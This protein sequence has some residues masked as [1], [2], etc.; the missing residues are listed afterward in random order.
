MTK[1]KDIEFLLSYQWR[2][3]KNYQVISELC[4]CD[5]APLSD[6]ILSSTDEKAERVARL[7]DENG[8]NGSLFRGLAVDGDAISLRSLGRI[9]KQ[10]ETVPRIIAQINKSP[11]R[12][13]IP[14]GSELLTIPQVARLLGW[15]ESVVRERNKKGL[16]PLP[17]RIGGT[18]QWRK[19]E[20][21]R[22]LE[23]DCPARQRWEQIKQGRGI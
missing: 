23:A 7:A 4:P 6:E 3:Q 2:L 18:I 1:P 11:D 19:R 14:E 22:W 16:L 5:L 12:S 15:G 8:F 9:H 13:A 21:L 20:V 10:I 17:I